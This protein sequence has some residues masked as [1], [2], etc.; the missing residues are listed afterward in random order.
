M[1]CLDKVSPFPFCTKSIIL[2]LDKHTVGRVV[3]Q[4]GNINVLRSYP[5]SSKRFLS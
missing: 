1:T 2:K 3:I 4:Q 5:R